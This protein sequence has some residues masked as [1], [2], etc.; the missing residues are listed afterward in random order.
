MPYLVNDDGMVP[1]RPPAGHPAA[2]L[3]HRA[4]RI[5]ALY[6]YERQREVL[7]KLMGS[8]LGPQAS[9]GGSIS[10]DS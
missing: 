8:V 6:E 7:Q 2:R 3:V 9:P 4:E 5:L 1:W 10:A